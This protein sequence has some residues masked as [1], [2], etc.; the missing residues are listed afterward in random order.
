[1]RPKRGHAG[2]PEARRS[3]A[4]QEWNASV[5]YASRAWEYLTD[6]QRLTWNVAASNRRT[7]GQRYF[8]QVNAPRIRDGE[9]LLTT[10]PPP[11]RPAPR[12]LLQELIITN[13]RGHISLK[14]RL[15]GVPA[16]RYTVW[17]ARPCNRGVSGAPKCP[18][19]GP[20]PPAVNHMSDITSLYF[21]KHGPYIDKHR[22]P[23]PGKRIYIRLRQEFDAG[24]GT[25]Q[26]VRA[27]VPG[28]EDGGA[29]GKKP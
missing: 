23:L 5:G 10:L 17:G 13:R 2:R 20:L 15:A 19:L 25:Y 7:T 1:M 3:A 22:L 14:L 6:E 18:R 8:V 16:G 9:A 12:P 21:L 29:R 26:Q 11:E 28:P 4:Q 27:I 24:P